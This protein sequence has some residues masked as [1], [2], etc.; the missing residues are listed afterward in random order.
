MVKAFHINFMGTVRVYG[1]GMDTWSEMDNFFEKNH[2]IGLM[3]ID[4]DV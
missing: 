1:G 2:L 4:F 3:F